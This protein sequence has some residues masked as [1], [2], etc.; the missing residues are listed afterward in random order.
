AFDKQRKRPARDAAEVVMVV[1]LNGDDVGVGLTELE[2]V[3]RHFMRR[4]RTLFAFAK[5]LAI[6]ENPR[7]ILDLAGRQ[8]NLF[9]LPLRRQEN[10]FAIPGIPVIRLVA[11]THI[12]RTIGGVARASGIVLHHPLPF[13][14]FRRNELLPASAV[15]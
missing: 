12:A 15:L 5:R 4:R 6:D 14:G 13:P 10:A 1:N 8:P 11:E 9:S 7:P 2:Q 3:A